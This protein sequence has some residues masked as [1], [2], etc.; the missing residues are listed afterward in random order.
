MDDLPIGF[1]MALAENEPALRHFA[2]L[3]DGTRQQIIAQ[4]RRARSREEMRAIVNS[5]I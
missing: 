3:N 4:A 2:S 1:T 5:L